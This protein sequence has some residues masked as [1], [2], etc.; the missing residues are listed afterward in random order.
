M[1]FHN[2][3]VAAIIKRSTIPVKVVLKGENSDAL[4]KSLKGSLRVTT[5]PAICLALPNGK[6]VD[7]TSWQS[8]R[9][10][11]AFLKDALKRQ[12]RSAAFE[13]MRKNDWPLACKAYEIDHKDSANALRVDLYDTIYWSVA[14]RHNNDDTTARKV[15]EEALARTKKSFKFDQKDNWPEPCVDYLLGN[16]SYDELMKLSATNKTKHSYRDETAHY[17]CGIKYLLDGNK[18]LAIKELRKI[19][20]DR[21]AR[22]L[23]SAKFA[24]AELRAL[25]ENYPEKDED[26]DL[27]YY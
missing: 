27:S 17:V 7:D 15:L 24:R 25:G 11:V 6:K 12:S 22:Y 16:I 20:D 5:T 8:D 3:E 18:E 4:S 19:A 1:L 10:F 9:M 13:A 23:Y 2:R 21:G 14:L 26:D